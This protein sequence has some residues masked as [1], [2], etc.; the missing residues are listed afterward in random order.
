MRFHDLPLTREMSLLIWEETRLDAISS[1]R[2]TR[3]VEPEAR[4][5][6]KPAQACHALRRLLVPQSEGPFPFM[7][8]PVEIRLAI[9]ELVLDF[10]PYIMHTTSVDLGTID[11]PDPCR[12]DTV[13]ALTGRTKE[14]RTTSGSQLL[15]TDRIPSCAPSYK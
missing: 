14:G 9:Y 8:L 7:R 4:Y 1:I 3:R 5:S 11:K 6:I 12:L 13:F 2:F 15:L 10:S